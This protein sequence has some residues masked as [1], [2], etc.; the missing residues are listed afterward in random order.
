M[1][2]T[3]TGTGINL[4]I[5]EKIPLNVLHKMHVASALWELIIPDADMC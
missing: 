2:L 1:I 3:N 4:S 5:N